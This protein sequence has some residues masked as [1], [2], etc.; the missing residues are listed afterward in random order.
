M[1]Y[2]RLGVWIS[3]A[4]LGL[5]ALILVLTRGD[6]VLVGLILLLGA[7]VGTGVV[8]D[9]IDYSRMAPEKRPKGWRQAP[10][11]HWGYRGRPG[12]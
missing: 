5:W 3:A 11:D 7:A 9:R 6:A 10:H 2:V 8:L 12:S 1:R 4:A